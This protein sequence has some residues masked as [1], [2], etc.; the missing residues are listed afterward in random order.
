MRT[1]AGR[2]EPDIYFRIVHVVGD[3]FPGAPV[4]AY[5]DQTFEIAMRTHVGGSYS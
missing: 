4:A 1:G 5:R 3:A 2:I